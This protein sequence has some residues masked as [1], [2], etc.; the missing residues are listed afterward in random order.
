[1]EWE[2]LPLETVHVVT[3]KNDEMYPFPRRPQR[4]RCPSFVDPNLLK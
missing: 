2:L 4:L 1:M 3:A